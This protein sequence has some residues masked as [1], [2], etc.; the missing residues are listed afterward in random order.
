MTNFY[1]SS[2]REM[3]V[4]VI[5][6][7]I[8]EV[9][10]ALTPVVLGIALDSGLERGAT[11][12]VWIIAGWLTILALVQAITMAFGHGVEIVLWMRT[13]LRSINQVHNHVTRSGPA[14]LRQRS[15]GEVVATTMSD[16]EHVGNLV[17]V[18]PRLI[19]SLMAFMTVAIVLLLQHTALGLVVL[20][21][22]PVITALAALLIK[23]LQSRQQVQRDEQGKLTSLGTDT[24]AGLR[25]LRGIGGEAQ[26]AARYAEQSQKVRLAGN[27]V[28]RLQS[29]I[30]GLQILIPGVFT[31][32]V[33]WQGALLTMAGELTIGQF[34]ALFGLT[35]YLVRPLQIVMMVIT[36]FGRARVGAR[37]I[38]NVV[39][40]DPIAGTL[41]ERLAAEDGLP[42]W[43]ESDENPFDG[44]LFDAQTGI[45][46]Q[47]GLTTAIVSSKPEDSAALAERLARIDDDEAN[48]L[49]SGRDI[50]SLPISF[51]RDNVMLTRATPELF[52]GQLRAVID[53][54][55]P[56][57]IVDAPLIAAREKVYGPEAVAPFHADEDRDNE[58]LDALTAT[59]GHDVLS[60]LDNSLSG[61][62][63]EKARSLSGGQRQR[64]ALARSLVDAPKVLI[65]VEPTS[66]VDSHT[67]DRIADRLRARRS[68]KT[69][70]LVTSSPLMLDRVDDV[71]LLE[72]GRET[73]RGSHSELLRRAHA[74]DP[75]AQRYE[76]VITRQT[77]ADA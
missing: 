7:S 18:T 15:T 23:P 31:A 22:V 55:H 26:F 76:R 69:T 17:E 2:G 32:F 74:G 1:T 62:V 33:M 36:Q 14:I 3:T 35:I 34:T 67:E 50:R 11:S 4:A 48:V 61:E 46:I 39:R 77:G 64:V 12:S 70:V 49:V 58:L 29:W 71:V 72:D 45:L 30:D 66:A 63:T 16:S 5:S 37:K 10:G 27:E 28:A 73:I 60:S 42:V 59:D 47:P 54:K 44:P 68:G 57:E 19:G 56:Y 6:R 8:Q 13:A 52:G 38:F 41:D 65:L 40:I 9:L 24:V 53:A 51:V 43:D 20:I 21:G 75:A 25:V